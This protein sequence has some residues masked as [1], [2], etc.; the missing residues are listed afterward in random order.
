MFKFH[1]DNAQGNCASLIW[2]EKYHCAIRILSVFIALSGTVLIVVHYPLQKYSLR[3]LDYFKKYPRKALKILQ[4]PHFLDEYLEVVVTDFIVYEDDEFVYY[5]AKSLDDYWKARKSP[6][7]IFGLQPG[8]DC[9]YW[10]CWNPWDNGLDED[11]VNVE[12]H[13]VPPPDI[14]ERLKEENQKETIQPPSGD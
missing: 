12:E 5:T 14:L 13:V 11:E 3:L 2:F 4:N 1:P 9:L 7:G 10:S 8:L 6:F